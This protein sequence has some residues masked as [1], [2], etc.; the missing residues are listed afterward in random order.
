MKLY[1]ALRL[2]Q[3]IPAGAALT[4]VH[5]ACGFTPLHL[6]TFLAAEISRTAGKKVEIDTGLYGDLGGSL[7]NAANTDA[8]A[9]ICA[10]EWPDLDPRLGLRSLGGWSP[11]RFADIL[12]TARQR[13]ANFERAIE[14]L[15]AKIPAVLSLPTLPLPPISFTSGDQASAFEHELRL[16]LAESSAR[17][18]RL[19]GVKILSQARLDHLSPADAR[20]DVK[21]ELLTG[22]PY[23]LPHAARMAEMFAR[24]VSGA[25]PKKGLITDL[26]G[27]L[28]KGLVGEIG[29]GEVS[30]TLDGRAQIHGLYQQLLAAL[31]DAGVLLA[32]A[33]KNDP[34]VVHSALARKDLVLA[35]EKLFPIEAGWEPK[36]R[37][38][39]RILRAWNI[40]AD[41]VVF[42]DDSPMELA[43]VAASHPDIQC[44]LF[45]GDEQMA[46]NV[47]E[48]LRDCFAKT[49]LREEDSL[50]AASIRSGAGQSSS[51]SLLSAED[52][53]ARSEPEFSAEYLRSAT[54]ER[55]LELLNKTNQFNLNGKRYTQAALQRYLDQPGAFM[56]IVSYKD[57]YGPLG[58]IAVLCGCERGPTLQVD[59]WVMSCR[60][61]SRRIEHWCLQEIFSKFEVRE[62]SFNFQPT[63]RN[64]PLREFLARA[65]GEVP[66]PGCTLARAD[67]E[68]RGFE[69]QLESARG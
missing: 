42:V 52:F 60:A 39:D 25:I 53:L 47:L 37:S 34:E 16:I 33:S 57:K 13:M 62:I 4:R 8:E 28:W 17:L 18:S 21:S 15:S 12:E 36:S 3:K 7:L 56:L 6:K 51:L 48:E 2:L 59:A 50:R 9:V 35:A 54:D 44:V 1:D 38:V 10:L 30:W 11:A 40:G 63:G 65:A 19:T 20:L 24:L 23:S 14:K 27:T 43:E 61:F 69:V 26:D 32:C 49:A 22:F 64:H 68:A 29:P 31:S 55:A 46:Y 5:L 45:P 67:F 41:A 58:K 66:S